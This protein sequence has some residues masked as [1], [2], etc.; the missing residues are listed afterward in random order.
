MDGRWKQKRVNCWPLYVRLGDTLGPRK[1]MHP[2]ATLSLDAGEGVGDV[3]LLHYVFLSPLTLTLFHLLACLPCFVRFF[4]ANLAVPL[5]PSHVLSSPPPSLSFSLN[6]P[7]NLVEL[8]PRV[9][10]KIVLIFARSSSKDIY[11]NIEW[12]K[13]MIYDCKSSNISIASYNWRIL[14]NLW[15]KSVSIRYRS[16]ESW[17]NLAILGF[18][19]FLLRWKKTRRRGSPRREDCRNG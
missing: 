15:T 6:H 11:I 18:D 4:S 2:H 12:W 13:Y 19:S 17:N 1:S 10:W 5:F 14:S 3:R 8:I 16:I 7:T 9:R